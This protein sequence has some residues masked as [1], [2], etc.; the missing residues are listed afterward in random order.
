MAADGELESLRSA[1]VTEDERELQAARVEAFRLLA[2]AAEYRDGDTTQHIERVSTTAAGIAARLGLDAEQVAL[3]REAAALHDLGKLAIPDTILLKPNKLTEQEYELVKTHA[4]LGAHLLAESSS[5]VLQMAAVIAASHHE[6][7]D[8]TGYPSGLAGE[9][10]PLVGR[11]VA[12]ADV[13]DALTHDRPYKSLWP[14]EQAIAEVQHAA[15]SQFDPRVVAAFL[16]MCSEGAYSVEGGDSRWSTAPVRPVSTA[17][18]RS[19]SAS[20]TPGAP[21]LTIRAR[22]ADASPHPVVDAGS[23]DQ[24]NLALE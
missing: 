6:R 15:A 1:E 13:F 14:A 12:V 18:Q 3:V 9:E 20:R 17:P 23:R 2:L 4:T 16:D 22:D 11:V 19:L 8:G 5:P 7:W 24:A 21:G 10:I